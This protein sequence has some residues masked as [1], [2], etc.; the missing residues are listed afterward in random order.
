MQTEQG[1]TRS[2][3]SIH[4]RNRMAA[5]VMLFAVVAIASLWHT[6]AQAQTTFVERVIGHAD[7][8]V[9]GFSLNDQG[10]AVWSTRTG[11][12]SQVYLWHDGLS[13][14]ITLGTPGT[15]A[16]DARIN[17]NNW[18]VWNAADENFTPSIY[19]WQ[20]GGASSVISTETDYQDIFPDAPY[21]T[22]DAAFAPSIN[23]LNHVAWQGQAG[24]S[25]IDD[26]FY[27][28]PGDT[29]ASDLTWWDGEGVS[30]G[31]RLNDIGLLSYER[32]AFE[33]IDDPDNPGQTLEIIA[34]NMIL[35]HVDASGETPEMDLA[36]QITDSHDQNVYN[37]GL[38]NH[39]KMVWMQYNYDKL[40]WDVFAFDPDTGEI[41]N[42]TEDLDGNSYDFFQF[43]PTVNDAGTVAWYS[44][45]RNPSRRYLYWDTGNGWELIPV[46]QSLTLNGP[47]AINNTG[48]L[49]YAKGVTDDG[50]SAQGEPTHTTYDIV[51]AQAVSVPE[52]GALMMA[53]ALLLS[54]LAGVRLR[55][56]ARQ[57]RQH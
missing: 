26:I 28:R 4:G 36:Y 44:A 9:T 41:T 2:T 48:G 33:E 52:P 37:G 43:D 35:S 10:W 25:G 45:F 53:G 11:T 1:S 32:T 16:H 50:L 39:G 51:I 38:N 21:G 3:R 56:R 54:G 5:S 42:L 40:L 12:E 49:I 46:P 13:D 17:N 19:L 27:W 6:P 15:G 23:N 20:G 57:N 7:N 14:P 47:V 29:K 30:T 24:A 18:V 34:S 22:T 8:L 31:P 55:R